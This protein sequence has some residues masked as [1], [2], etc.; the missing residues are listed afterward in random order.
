MP[1][2]LAF[3]LSTVAKRPLNCDKVAYSAIGASCRRFAPSYSSLASV[4]I[5]LRIIRLDGFRLDDD[6]CV[7][8]G[9]RPALGGDGSR[10]VARGQAQCHCHGSSYRHS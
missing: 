7:A 1:L 2:F 9:Q 10:D 8:T 5:L 4:L 6:G 3:K